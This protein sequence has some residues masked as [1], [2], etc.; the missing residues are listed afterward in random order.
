KVWE[1][2]DGRLQAALKLQQAID[3]YIAQMRSMP[4]D[5]PMSPE[6][7]SSANKALA[8]IRLDVL[9]CQQPL[10]SASA[11]VLALQITALMIDSAT[12]APSDSSTMTDTNTPV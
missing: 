7:V 4:V 12:N 2:L 3:D 11:E 1:D 8:R 5:K 6:Q 9:D 10:R